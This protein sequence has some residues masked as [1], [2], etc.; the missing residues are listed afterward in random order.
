MKVLIRE[1]VNRWALSAYFNSTRKKIFYLIFLSHLYLHEDPQLKEVT[2]RHL[3]LPNLLKVVYA[4]WIRFN[5]SLK[6]TGPTCSI[7]GRS[8]L[9]NLLSALQKQSS[10]SVKALCLGHSFLSL[11]STPIRFLLKTNLSRVPWQNIPA[12]HPTQ[13]SCSHNLHYLSLQTHIFVQILWYRHHTHSERWLST[14][15]TLFC[16]LL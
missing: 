10:F 15:G 14:A 11:W 5:S 13:V 7:L 16:P 2:Q 6:S 12:P 1:E 4:R 8:G 9:I 3:S